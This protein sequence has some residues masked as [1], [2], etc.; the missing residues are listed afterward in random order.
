[1]AWDLECLDPAS[2]LVSNL[3]DPDYLR[4]V[5]DGSLES[6]Q[7]LFSEIDQGQRDQRK[8]TERRGLETMAP[9]KMN[10]NAACKALARSDSFDELI[11]S[12]LHHNA[13]EAC[14][15]YRYV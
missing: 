12:M 10:M 6:L 13:G 7:R 14:P 2:A 3:N 1:M 8:Q 5:C 9:M 4:I 11:G 15:N